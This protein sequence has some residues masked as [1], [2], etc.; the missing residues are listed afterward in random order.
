MKEKLH[1]I[2]GATKFVTNKNFIESCKAAQAKPV[3]D[4]EKKVIEG[5]EETKRLA[6]AA[7]KKEKEQQDKRKELGKIKQIMIGVC[8]NHL[9]VA[10]G[11]VHLGKSTVKTLISSGKELV[12]A[13]VKK[14]YG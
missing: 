7:K 2:G 14:K 10:D 3:G 9:D 5:E 8:R 13:Q 11:I 12:S 1:S 4:D 6:E